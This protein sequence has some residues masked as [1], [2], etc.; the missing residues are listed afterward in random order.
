M[1]RTERESDQRE[2]AASWQL[3]NEARCSEQRRSCLGRGELQLDPYA[4]EI[5]EQN[6]HRYLCS[7]CAGE[8]ADDI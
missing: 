6:I 4:R 7:H 3:P 8:L 2:S 1:S 5:G